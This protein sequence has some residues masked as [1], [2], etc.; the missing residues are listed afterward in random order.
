MALTARLWIAS[1]VVLVA[2][3]AVAVA[4]GPVAREKVAYSGAGCAGTGDSFFANEVWP[5]VGL[6]TCLECHKA[7]GDAEESEFV[8]TDPERSRGAGAGEVLRHN[9]EAFAR[10]AKLKEGDQSRMLL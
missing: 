6:Q 10:V 2:A 5:K 8:L 9:R 1:A 4:E 7:G 3:V